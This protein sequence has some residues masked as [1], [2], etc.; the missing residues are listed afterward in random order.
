MFA[1]KSCAEIELR[2]GRGKVYLDSSV[3]ASA[4]DLSA[5]YPSGERFPHNLHSNSRD[6]VL[7]R[8]TYSVLEHFNGFL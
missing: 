4:P 1:T 5:C 2:M 3:M 6:F 8:R 7:A